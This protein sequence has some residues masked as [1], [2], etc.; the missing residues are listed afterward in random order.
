VVDFP[1]PPFSLPSTTTC[2]DS[3]ASWIGWTNMARPFDPAIFEKLVHFSQAC[4]RLIVNP[5]GRI[6]DA[7][8][9]RIEVLRQS[10]N[11]A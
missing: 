7:L 11:K 10:T 2:A 9:G 5:H 3:D 1:E 6:N 8:L 4:H